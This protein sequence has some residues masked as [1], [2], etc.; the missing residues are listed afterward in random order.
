MH[1]GSDLK[2]IP[3]ANGIFTRVTSWVDIINFAGTDPEDV[4]FESGD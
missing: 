3:V 1:H 4:Y 2:L